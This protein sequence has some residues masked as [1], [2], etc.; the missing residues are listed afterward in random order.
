MEDF[1][2]GTVAVDELKVHRHRVERSGLQHAG[3][4]RPRD[5]QP[6][7]PVRILA[8]TG[9]DLPLEKVACYYTTDGS[10]PEGSFGQ[11]QHGSVLMLQPNESIW[12]NFRWGYLT[13]WEAEIPAQ[14]EGTL[15]R[16]RIGGWHEGGAEHFADFPD[17][18]ATTDRAAT[19]F[20][21]GREAHAD[22]VPG[23]HA[24]HVFSY[25]VD[26]FR[27]PRWAREAI[28]YQIFI[29]RFA[30]GPGRDWIQTGDL[31]QPFGGTLWGVLE[32]LD[33]LADLGV[34]CLWLSPT[35][36]TPSVH[37]YDVLDFFSVE[38]RIGGEQAMRELV[39]AAHD[40]EIR[41]LLD[42]VPNHISNKHP[43]FQEAAGDPASPYR[44][45]FTF[46][47]F[48]PGYRSFFGVSSMPE[49]NLSNPA[50]RQ[51]MIDIGTFW[52]REYDIDGYRL[53]HANGPGPSFWSEFWPACKRAKPDSFCF[54]EIVEPAEVL[55][56]Y[57]GR[58]DGTLDFIFAD[59]VRRFFR[60]DDLDHTLLEAF[61]Q[62]H[63]RYF[64]ADFLQLSF[65]DNHDMDRFLYITGG[66]KG[67]LLRAAE[68]QMELPGPPV[69]YYGTEVGLNQPSGKSS[70][71]GLEASRVPMI[72]DERQGQD[73]L[74]KYKEL[75]QERK[76]SQPWER[77]LK[78]QEGL[79]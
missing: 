19:N 42:L 46:E 26:R 45:W 10:K 32:K 33:Y 52:L 34:S 21:Q 47:D 1:I 48:G 5:P 54:S 25:H 3:A 67:K 66:D 9:P 39:Q 37:G 31:K 74:E 40:H 49:L 60:E 15:V 8:C 36:P 18:K 2:F 28:I 79:A 41:I 69:I 17:V 76:L 44:D 14:P 11:A 65:L 78:W 27:P 4:I 7:E 59:A 35:W 22:W 16:Y 75:I 63:F 24:G 73:V 51:W 57:T 71:D 53:D 68:L 6:G 72:W 62:K 38:P 55:R 20:F 64:E 56:R 58:L 61:L 50:T 13:R 12:D 43:Y 23:P 30:P 77:A 70:A 29:D